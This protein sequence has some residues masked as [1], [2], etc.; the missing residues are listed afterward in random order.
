VKD[1]VTKILIK[2]EA[3]GDDKIAAIARELEQL[4]AQGLAA[5]PAFQELANELRALQAAQPAGLDAT[6]SQVG[7]LGEAAADS[8]DALD[9]MGSAAQDA[10]GGMDELSEG[11]TGAADAVNELAGAQ[12]E[13]EGLAKAI[14]GIFALTQ[15]K[16]AASAAI[17]TADAFGQMAERIRMTTG[18]A[19]EYDYVQQR[20]LDTANATY[21]PLAEQQ[22]LYI[23]TAEALRS[24]GRSTSEALDITDSFSYLLTTN[25]ASADRAK[26]AI[27]AYAK[28]VQTGRVES[29]G[30]QSILAAM[31]TLVDALADSTGRSTREIRE[32]GITG[33][34]SLT[35]LNAALQQT[36]ASNKA[37]AAEMDTTVADAVQ[38]LANTWALYLGEVNKSYGV[39]E[40][41][42]GIL[43][44]LS[45]NLDGLMLAAT[46]AG[47]TA[48][49][50]ATV[51]AELAL[52]RAAAAVLA[53]AGSAAGAAAINRTF[54]MSVRNVAIAYATI[55]WATIISN[56]IELVRQK[57]A[58]KQ[59]TEDVA[60]KEGQLS[61]R[62]AEI[63]AAT[64][65]TVTSMEELN[66][67]E[68]E[69][70]IH[71][72]ALTQSWK[73]GPAALSALDASMQHLGAGAR[74]LVTDYYALREA[75]QSTAEALKGAFA[76]ITNPEDW[77]GIQAMGEALAE[78]G[79]TGEV[80]ARQVADA[81]RAALDGLSGTELATF[82]RTAS[83]VFGDTANEA[84]A[85]TAALT[86][87]AERL[88]EMS[89]TELAA[90]G[91]L[92]QK[93]MADGRLEAEAFARINDAV[94]SASF[95]RL[96]A[97][98]AA[99]LG[100]ISPAAQEAI[101]SV[102]G[103]VAALDA[104]QVGAEQSATAIEM[105][106][107]KAFDV[108]DSMT[109]LDELNARVK[110]LGESGK[111]G[112]EGMS[113]LADAASDARKRLE[114][115]TPGIQSVEEAFR[116][117][118]I[119]SAAELQKAA[120]EARQA[121]DVIKN[122]GTATAQDIE[123]AFQ[124][125]AD[126]AVAA[127]GDVVDASVQ[128]QAAQLGL[129]VE[130]DEAGKVF[131]RSMKEAA[132]AV[133]E[134]EKGSKDAA[135]AAGD[136]ADASEDVADASN[137]AATAS[138]GVST[139]WVDAAKAG[140]QYAAEAGR[141]AQATYE[142]QMAMMRGEQTVW[143]Y[144]R[145]LSAAMEAGKNA[146]AGYIGAMET[147]DRQQAALNNSALDGYRDMELQLLRLTGTREQIAAAEKARDEA[148][149]QRQ[150]ALAKIEA[151]RAS[152]RGEGDEARRLQEE[153]KLYE[154]QLGLLDKI[155]REQEKQAKAAE[156]EAKRRE[157][158]AEREAKRREREQREQERER[159]TERE[160][161]S[162]SNGGG[163]GGSDQ[164]GRPVP[165][166]AGPAPGSAR[167]VNM[168]IAIGGRQYAM[169]NM[170][171]QSAQ[172]LEAMLRDLERAA[173]VAQ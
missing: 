148:A 41:L 111:I 53:Y 137:S 158:E 154:K 157:Q 16:Q 8:A 163:G 65:V 124:A 140:S 72:D 165:P 118:G 90:F 168:N 1:L 3:T 143:S 55:E 112:A 28:A 20:L 81:W 78:L 117:L 80:S 121:F 159:A 122:S 99:A 160:R 33:T 83:Q 7:A 145:A 27:D 67:A 56:L 133:K 25:A 54:A 115:A 59:V 60:E 21:R 66:A 37:A 152:M 127:N 88:G 153:I 104:A 87:T 96:G 170:P 91:A 105:A 92:A 61:T 116:Q 19:E 129:K 77:R 26:S 68:A 147:L 119:T 172:T 14:A 46:A 42:V 50:A 5:T 36:V 13:I 167:T 62:L 149:I 44:T 74:A 109:A 70:R 63:S 85:L 11:A 86:A 40:K 71:F 12:P 120:T 103:I 29:D 164:N 95:A 57:R 52:R 108:A 64:G 89:G 144:T 45:D 166:P 151:Q 34:L 161:S 130:A 58:L 30:W 94:L 2:A 123:R 110:A 6:A 18:S 114:D 142:A 132:E 75:G 155:Y 9:S 171:E 39:T 32:L 76:N 24:M 126:A 47:M 100:K 22:E 97:N 173:G 35:E 138:R 82:A 48:L 17:E 113:R 31:P 139:A 106:L 51:A 134:V 73:A 10:R 23:R 102:D 38:R 4:A 146:A 79:G 156:K 107:G 43:D 150:I 125:Y 131:L 101:D 93:A 136:L 98:A 69:G 135:E 169:P 15:V 49:V 84:S 162:P 141:Y 128:A